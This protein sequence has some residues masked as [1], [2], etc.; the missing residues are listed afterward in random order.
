[1][2]IGG[3]RR[4]SL[5]DF[6]GRLACTVFLSGCN[7]RCPYCHNPALVLPAEHSRS[8][9]PESELFAFLEQRRGKLDGVCIS[10]GEPT[11]HKELPRL[12]RLIRQSGFLTKLDTNGTAPAMLEAL[13]REGL[14]DYCGLSEE[15]TQAAVD[16]FFACYIQHG[17]GAMFPFRGIPEMLRSL[18]AA[19]KTI[20]IATNGVGSNARRVLHG[21][22]ADIWFDEI[23]GL[24]TLGAAET[25][26]DVINGLLKTFAIQDR[27]TAVMVGDRNFDMAAARA[28]G[29]DSIGVL[30][31][32]GTEEELSAAGATHLAAT[33]EELRALLDS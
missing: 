31:G 15:E 33:P 29:I 26:S 24:S 18:K 6:P 19:G 23:S 12:L 7:L 17:P 30:Y 9:L 14:L 22:G 1:M 8:G 21:C 4:L 10:G 20:A 2:N 28:C 25:K 11:L 5:L 13:L 3:L 16:A 27:S 32:Y